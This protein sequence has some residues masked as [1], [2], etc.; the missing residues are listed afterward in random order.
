MT[1]DRA[2]DIKQNWM[3][4][5]RRFLMVIFPLLVAVGG[6]V[7]YLLTGRFVSTD[8]AYVGAAQV[9]VSTDVSGRVVQIPL[10]DNQRV[11]KGQ[12]LLKIDRR[13]FLIAQEEAAANLASVRM[14]IAA[15]KAN[16]RGRLADLRSAENTL[17]YQQKEYARQEKLAKSGIASQAQLDKAWQML[18][19]ARQSVDA[20]QQGAK[21]TLA[22]LGGNPNIR[23][24]DH[25]SVQAARAKLDQ[26]K[27]NLSYTTVTA[28]ADGIVTKVEQVQVGDF[29]SKATALFA[30]VSSKDIWIEA[31]FKETD[32]TYMRPG[33]K[34]SIEVDAYPGQTLSGKVASISPGTGASFSLL[35]PQ[36]ATG[37][38][39]KIVQRVP[40]RIT[41]DQA[42]HVPLQV[43]LSV[44]AVVDTKHRRTLLGLM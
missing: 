5:H 43:G 41:L 7:F 29:V 32:L 18:Q 13:P 27:L 8:D 16:Y 4:R 38:W 28:P 39:V 37:N 35:P 31:N 20:R 9:E 14:Q 25:P 24:E 44:S 1:T 17:S 2:D 10:V 36:N 42:V 19:T 23:I 34:A 15:M 26:A 11:H 3:G 33:Q 22:A 30:L 12:V 21:T 6:M 40:V